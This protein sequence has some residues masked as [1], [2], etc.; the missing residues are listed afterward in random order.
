MI[1]LFSGH[2][3]QLI[4]AH[5]YKTAI[6]HRYDVVV[7][8]LSSNLIRYAI[9]D[10]QVQT[11]IDT[12]YITY[13]Y[14]LQQQMTKLNV[15]HWDIH[16][17]EPFIIEEGNELTFVMFIFVTDLTDTVHTFKYEVKNILNGTLGTKLKYIECLSKK[18]W[19][20]AGLLLKENLIYNDT[21]MLDTVNGFIMYID[22]EDKKIAN[23]NVKGVELLISDK[24]K[25]Q[26]LQHHPDITLP[27]DEI[28]VVNCWDKHQVLYKLPDKAEKAQFQFTN[29]LLYVRFD[30][31]DVVFHENFKV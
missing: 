14:Q 27:N 13:L 29:G 23:K 28:T 19:L 15:N 9:V 2:Y 12:G 31:P 8:L 22:Y 6:E 16:R 11:L 24:D 21:K 5:K 26:F 30:T 25:A 10:R 1:P 3:K 4:P 7:A 18:K 20:I 17:L